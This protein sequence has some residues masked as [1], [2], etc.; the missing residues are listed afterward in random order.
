MRFPVPERGTYR[1]LCGVP[2]HGLSGMW[3]WLNVDRRRTGL[4]SGRQGK[5]ARTTAR[6]ETQR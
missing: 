2:G 4:A 6:E 3:I 1:I 5:A